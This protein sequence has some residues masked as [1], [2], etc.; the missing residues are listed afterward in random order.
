MIEIVNELL[1]YS[2]SNQF[3]IIVLMFSGIVKASQLMTKQLMQLKLLK[4]YQFAL[5]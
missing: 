4:F 2:K 1:R 5:F 3:E